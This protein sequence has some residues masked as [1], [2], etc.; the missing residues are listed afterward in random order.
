MASKLRVN[1]TLTSLSLAGNH[2]GG[3]GVTALA[4]ALRDN[5][6]LVNLSLASNEIDADA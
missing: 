3:A 5:R 2:F 6:T 1:T 4:P